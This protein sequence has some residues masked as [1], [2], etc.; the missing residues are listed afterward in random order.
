VGDG[1]VGK[2]SLLWRWAKREFK[3]EHEPTVFENYSTQVELEDQAG[4]KRSQKLTLWDTAGQEQFDKLRKLSYPGTS[5]F[6]VC[7][8]VDNPASYESVR[9]LWYPEIKQHTETASIVLVGTKLD[10]RAPGQGV[11]E[12]D[13][14][15]LAREI[16][17][18]RY[19]ECSAK[20]DVDSVKAVFDEAIRCFLLQG[21]TGAP[22]RPA[23]PPKSKGKGKC[24][25]L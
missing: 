4:E 7:F 3:P 9:S 20:E 16:G 11:S 5:V 15:N 22:Q 18:A 24:T 17:A 21:Q 14:Q 23:P 10:L 25:I 13:G 8:S 19:K 2:T 6:L 1:A 12:S